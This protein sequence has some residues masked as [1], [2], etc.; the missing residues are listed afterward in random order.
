[1]KYFWNFI[2]VFLLSSFVFIT[3]GLRTDI[4]YATEDELPSYSYQVPEEE[5]G[6]ILQRNIET[7]M[8]KKSLTREVPQYSSYDYVPI[9]TK[10][11]TG[12]GYAGNRSIS[13]TRFPTGGGFF[14]SGSGGPSVSASVSFGITPISIGISLGNSSSSGKFVTVP[15]T[16][17]YFK[18]RVQKTNKVV[19][20]A[21][22]GYPITGGNRVFL[23]YIYPST[24]YSESAWAER[25]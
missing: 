13:G 21:V 1:M 4:A 25:Q 16:T 2:G 14:W 24:L 18:L 7:I 9:A 17:N 3:L 8:L 15:N 20:T 22:Y 12:A 6:K 10:Y 23:Y 5:Q 19:Q 11:A